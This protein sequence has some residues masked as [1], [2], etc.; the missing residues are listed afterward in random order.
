MPCSPC[1]Y[2]LLRWKAGPKLNIAI[3]SH[4]IPKPD[5][6]TEMESGLTLALSQE[7]MK[8]NMDMEVVLSFGV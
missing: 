8:G 7:A 2:V 6:A 3:L 1:A 5:E 4:F